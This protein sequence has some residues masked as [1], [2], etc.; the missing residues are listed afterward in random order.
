[1]A[2]VL[3]AAA[4]PASAH[5]SEKHFAVQGQ[6]VVTV[7]AMA[8]GR[9]EVKSWRNP[10]VVVIGNHASNKIEVDSEQV[11]NRIEV[12]TTLLDKTAAQPEREASFEITVP[13]STELQMHTDSGTIYVEHVYGD[14]TFD[15]VGGDVHLRD[16]SGYVLVKTVGGS[17]LCVECAGK[18]NFNS[19]SGNVQ[20]LQPQL[21]ALDATTTSGNILYDGQFLSHGI[22]KMKTGTGWL[23]VHFSDTDSFDL[24][25]ATDHGRVDNQAQAFLKP[26][27]HGLH[28]LPSKFAKGIFGTVNAGLAHVELSSFSG[29]IRIRKRD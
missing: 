16:I 19:I 21:E 12:F 29:T 28:H 15:T 20:I 4:V 3:L 24:R 25:A 7:N 22:Y 27:P 26:D 2:A 10:E 14:M 6:P 23:E 17:V 5:R 8:N 18:L 9:I 13:E 11:G 1:V